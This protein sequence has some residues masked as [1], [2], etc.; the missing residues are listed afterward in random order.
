MKQSNIKT[1]IQSFADKLIVGIR[2]HVEPSELHDAAKGYA[3]AMYKAKQLSPDAMP[4]LDYVIKHIE[5]DNES[6]SAILGETLTGIWGLCR[7][8]YEAHSIDAI[9]DFLTAP[10]PPGGD[11][12]FAPQRPVHALALTLLDIEDSDSVAC[13][14]VNG[15]MFFDEAVRTCKPAEYFLTG[16]DGSQAA[17][18]TV[19]AVLLG[20]KVTIINRREY[21]YWDQ[22]QKFAKMF[23]ETTF[24]SDSAADFAHKIG[25]VKS[26]GS[27]HGSP[28]W[29]IIHLIA[30]SITDDGK[31]AV[32]MTQGACINDADRKYRKHFVENGLIETVIDL[33]KKKD[34]DATIPTALVVISKGNKSIR[35]VDATGICKRGRR[36]NEVN[37]EHIRSIVEATRVDSEISRA[38]ALDMFAET[39]Y[40][41]APGKLLTKPDNIRNGVMFADVI[42]SI[43]RGSRLPASEIN[44]L[45][46]SE[47]TGYQYIMLGDIQ[48]GIIRDDLPF[49]ESL[50]PSQRKH[51]IEHGDLLL[52][53][54]G[55]PPKVA[56]VGDSISSTILAAENLFIIKLEKSRINPLYVAA[57]FESERG[58][59]ALESISFGT[60]LPTVNLTALRAMAI[61][62]PPL[63]EQQAIAKRYLSHL[64]AI[65]A[66][67]S[68]LSSAREALSSLFAYA[69]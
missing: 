52:G 58:R 8:V 44:L 55:A 29:Q 14:G 34:S 1:S 23:S 48:D 35:L 18:A 24:T 65:K 11:M 21:P 12:P 57:Y 5:N 41:I 15:S 46:A 3:Y 50:E 67:K 37:D 19:C 22:E 62:C 39:N 40:I 10:N 68:Q 59:K 64:N 49:L 17:A 47:P 56:V 20:L 51:C 31:A 13:F 4:L 69:E 6:L 38:F 25:V 30:E 60:R 28:S 42:T 33:P 66:L 27:S 53:K 7:D 63:A 43:T 16:S 9:M 36:H 26:P 61:P 32:V 54:Y 45:T 2:S